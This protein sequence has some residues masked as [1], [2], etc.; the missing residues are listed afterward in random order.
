M[1]LNVYN[2]YGVDYRYDV[3]FDLLYIKKI[4]GGRNSG[5]QVG[6]GFERDGTVNPQLVN[7][8]ELYERPPS[9][10]GIEEG[11]REPGWPPGVFWN[12]S[13]IG[14][15]GRRDHLLGTN[16]VE[17]ISGCGGDDRLEGRGGDDIMFG[18]IGNDLLYGGDGNDELFGDDGNDRLY[19]GNGNDTLVGGDG[20]GR[21]LLDGGSGYDIASYDEADDPVLV[22]LANPANSRGM[23]EGNRHISIEEVIGS[24]RND[25]L[26]GDGGDNVLRGNYAHDTLDGRSGDDRLYGESGDDS[27]YGRAGRDRLD[28]GTGSDILYGGD[29]DDQLYGGDQNDFLYGGAGAD[30][31]DGGSGIDVAS[32]QIDA[33]GAVHVDMREGARG[34]G[35]AAGDSFHSIE[36]VVGTNFNDRIEG[37]D[38]NNELR[39]GGGNDYVAGRLG[40]DTLIGGVGD[41]TLFGGHG[42]DHLWGLTGADTFVFENQPGR[43]RV[44]GFK[45]NVDEIQLSRGLARSV[46]DALDQGRQVGANV[47][48]TFDG[49]T[50]LIVENVT[51]NQLSNDILIA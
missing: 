34:K 40:N 38:E 18:A 17:Y 35:A 46:D 6:S 42:N 37:N 51:L 45:N 5:R 13:G 30:R 29:G 39:G 3:Y 47:V 28:G 32:Y 1:S 10:W 25:T 15:T 7:L 24:P 44:F 19:G 16:A 27:L 14:G 8:L 23:A 50:S 9:H 48:F 31:L 43:D 20:G 33:P 49:D 12:W 21:D 41:D 22:D 2:L 4:A 26:R 36:V 11:I